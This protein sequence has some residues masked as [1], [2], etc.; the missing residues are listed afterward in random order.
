MIDKDDSETPIPLSVTV[1]TRKESAM[2]ISSTEM[3]LV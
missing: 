3:R 1:K 2:L